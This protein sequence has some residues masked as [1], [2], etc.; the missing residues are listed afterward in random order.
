MRKIQN[1]YENGILFFG[2]WGHF[3]NIFRTRMPLGTQ[4]SKSSKKVSKRFS[5]WLS[6]APKKIPIIKKNVTQGATEGMQLLFNQTRHP[7]P[8]T[9]KA[10]CPSWHYCGTTIIT[11]LVSKHLG[12]LDLTYPKTVYL[13]RFH[14]CFSG[15]SDTTP[16]QATCTLLS[17]ACLSLQP[18]GLLYLWGALRTLGCKPLVVAGSGGHQEPMTTSVARCLDISC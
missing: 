15:F 18:Q 16:K 14:P 4:T 8:H 5:K 13:F 3:F 9:R 7:V 10:K 17:D 1:S 2:F 6:K 11:H 12:F